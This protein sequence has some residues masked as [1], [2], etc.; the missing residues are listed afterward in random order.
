MLQR[1]V[2]VT[3]STF[4]LV[5]VERSLTMS[6]VTV[7]RLTVRASNTS[8]A[9]KPSVNMTM[10]VLQKKNIIEIEIKTKIEIISKNKF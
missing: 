8:I 7:Q 10:K 1:V 4:S 9:V 2:V 6:S 3:C 5:N